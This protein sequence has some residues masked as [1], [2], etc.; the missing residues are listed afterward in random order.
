MSVL[1]HNWTPVYPAPLEVAGVTPGT[2]EVPTIVPA[3]WSLLES[4]A[5]SAEFLLTGT[6]QNVPALSKISFKCS[7][8]SN[9]Y[10]M[11]KQNAIPLSLQV[12]GLT[13]RKVYSQYTAIGTVTDDQN[14]MYFVPVKTS[15]MF[16]LPT[17]VDI[18]KDDLMNQMQIQL[19]GLSK[20]VVDGNVE[21]FDRVF[22]MANGALRF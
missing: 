8:V 7:T 15:V 20:V 2:I 4:T 5:D 22:A 6:E 11:D 12:P 9:P 1:L 21:P 17:G 14:N 13:A 3:D 16:E 19:S 18:S 10:N